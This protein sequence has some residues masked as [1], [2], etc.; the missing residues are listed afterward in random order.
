MGRAGRVRPG[1][2]YRMFSK[3]R[4]ESMTPFQVPEILRTPLE[5]VILQIKLLHLTGNSE[6]ASA[7]AAAASTGKAVGEA[8]AA[9][10]AV[11]VAPLPAGTVLTPALLLAQLAATAPAPADVSAPVPASE[12]DS[13]DPEDDNPFTALR[14]DKTRVPSSGS[15]GDVEDDDTDDD[16]VDDEGL[17]VDVDSSDDDAELL[18]EGEVEAK[19]VVEKF[20]QKAL[21]PPQMFAVRRAI[22]L[23]QDIGALR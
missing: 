2:C 22:R 8:V 20:L 15:E 11:P 9:K 17:G 23:L 6:V 7:A 12:G 18:M 3:Q 5:E 14:K 4:F 19:G 1:M 21:Q 16:G 13:T 10:V